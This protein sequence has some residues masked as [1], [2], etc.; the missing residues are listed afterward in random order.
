M[1][2]TLQLLEGDGVGPQKRDAAAVGAKGA[3][4]QMARLGMPFGM[5]GAGIVPIHQNA[6]IAGIE[7]KRHEAG[8]IGLLVDERELRA[9]AEQPLINVMADGE[10]GFA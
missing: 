6:A 7:I 10:I 9:G 1:G 8:R 5:M 3:L 2:E 4:R